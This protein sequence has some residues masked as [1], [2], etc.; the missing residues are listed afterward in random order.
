M[1]PSDRQMRSVT[2]YHVTP[3]ATFPDQAHVVSFDL[4][5]APIVRDGLV[6]SP[7]HDGDVAVARTQFFL[8]PAL[9]RID[10]AL[11]PNRDAAP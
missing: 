8:G 11:L 3:G 4:C 1:K 7:F 5:H 9:D 6:G 2:H 10:R